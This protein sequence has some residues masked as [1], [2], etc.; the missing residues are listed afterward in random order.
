MLE[1]ITKD[2][3]MKDFNTLHT[4]FY[5][6]S[7][8]AAYI[9][10]DKANEITG[11]E[12]FVRHIKHTVNSEEIFYIFDG[13]IEIIEYMDKVKSE[14]Y[15]PEFLETFIELIIPKVTADKQLIEKLIRE[16]WK[17]IN[18]EFEYTVIKNGTKVFPLVPV[19]QYK[20]AKWLGQILETMITNIYN[21]KTGMATLKYFKEQGRDTFV[22]DEEFDF[23]ERLMNDEQEAINDYSEM[24]TQ[25]AKDFRES[26]DKILLE[27]A[28]RRCPS[29]TT[30]DMASQIAIDNG[31]DGTSNV[32]LRL[33]DQITDAQI[34]GTMAHSFVMSFEKERDA[35]IAWDKIFPGT[36]I[37]IDTYDV[38]NA[39]ELIRDM[40][41]KGEIT[42][43]KDVRIDSD[44]LD[45]YS[46]QVDEIFNE[47][48]NGKKI[49]RINSGAPI[50]N[51]VSGD[52]NIEK[53]EKF[54]FE[55]IP[56]TKS[57]AGSRYVYSNIIVEKLNS[58]FVYKIVEFI[59]KNGDIIRPQKKAN[60]KGN[61]PGLKQCSYN[62]ISNEL[63]VWCGTKEGIFGF[64]D[65]D[66]MN[67]DTKVVF[68]G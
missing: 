27:A 5:Q 22:S 48:F 11:F 3:K 43:P 68:K 28:F 24:L 10:N 18:K 57:M 53:F 61:H 9:I 64:N 14:I 31:W 58:G 13:E 66:K 56:Y 6:L 51:F 26:T 38:V 39:A 2:N 46:V 62:A 32:S 42:A 47:T 17:T 49:S 50:E 1:Q 29:K 60:G 23:L 40:V 35:F 54:E 20:G 25:T 52:M 55:K 16:Q 15:D 67:T 30:A 21:G 7:M 59:N 33:R 19:F 34:G 63:T 4:D 37:L 41:D 36:T 44:P 8:T 45:I 12:G 65:M